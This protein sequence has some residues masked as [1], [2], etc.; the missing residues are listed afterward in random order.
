MKQRVE[1]APAD[2]EF[3]FAFGRNWSSY[4]QKLSPGR[5][6][7]AT[8]SLRALLEVESMAGK[9]FLDVGSGSG[10]FSLGARQLGARVLS[11]D[12]DGDSV[13]CT[14]AL[15]D[16]FFPADQQWDVRQGSVLDPAFLKSLGQHDVVYAWGVLH[17]TGAMW[18]ACRNVCDLVSPG[19]VLVVALYNDQGWVS[20]GW[21]A[22]KKAYCS[23][24][25]A[26]SAV[27][28]T[29]IPYFALRGLVGDL[30]KGVNPVAR[31]RRDAAMGRG[32][33][34]VNDWLD[35]LG[36]YPFEVATPGQVVGFFRGAGFDLLQL[37]TVGGSHGNNEF[38]FLRAQG[39]S[40]GGAE[41]SA[42]GG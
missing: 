18:P 40:P 11:F 17:H 39:A 1:D 16:R 41:S 22:V 29:F 32:M 38:V 20:R 6:Q 19:G 24:A 12:F 2:P 13:A 5:I 42:S 4:L 27:Q 36:G 3:R 31:Y 25:L 23:G 21:G 7:E 8:G 26:R 30:A 33:A 10:L 37:R 28:A 14:R 9:T 34:L 35:W 15:R